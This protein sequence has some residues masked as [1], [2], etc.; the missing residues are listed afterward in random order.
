MS[1]KFFLYQLQKTLKMTLTIKHSNLFYI[2]YPL[3]FYKGAR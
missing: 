3:L 2:R 1:Y